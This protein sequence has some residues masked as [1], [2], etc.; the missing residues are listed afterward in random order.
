[1]SPITITY[2]IIALILASIPMMI[3]VARGGF[4]KKAVGNALLRLMSDDAPDKVL[5][6]KDA[7]DGKVEILDPK[8]KKTVIQTVLVGKGH[9]ARYPEKAPNWLSV[10]IKEYR[11]VD[12]SQFAFNIKVKKYNPDGST[13]EKDEHVIPQMPV[14]YLEEPDPLERATNLAQLRNET[15]TAVVIEQGAKTDELYKENERLRKSKNGATS[16]LAIVSIIMLIVIG[17][18]LYLV[19]TKA[20]LIVYGLKSLGALPW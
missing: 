11:A 1:M 5:L 4:L 9:P 10:D 19:Y 6:V 14:F 15:V 2:A 8:N 7:M 16:M 17:A 3:I 18:G 13:Y 12:G 20:D